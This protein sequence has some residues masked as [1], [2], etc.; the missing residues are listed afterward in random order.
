M[1]KNVE[2][3]NKDLNNN[4][5]PLREDTLEGLELMTEGSNGPLLDSSRKLENK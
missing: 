5:V 2:E 4:T 1:D 3:Q